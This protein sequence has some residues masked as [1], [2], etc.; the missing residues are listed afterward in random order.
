MINPEDEFFFEGLEQSESEIRAQLPLRPQIRY[1][2]GHFPGDPIL[3]AVAVVDAAHLLIKKTGRVGRLVEIV[4]GKFTQAS[5]AGQK[6]EFRASLHQQTETGLEWRVEWQE[7]GSSEKSGELI[8]LF[9]R[10]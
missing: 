10:L 4:N 9:A 8:F 5:R 1:F 3:P 6:L 2:T 7:V